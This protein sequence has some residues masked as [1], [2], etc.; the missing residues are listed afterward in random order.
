MS[1][2]VFVICLVTN[3]SYS[4]HITSVVVVLSVEVLSPFVIYIYT[5]YIHIYVKDGHGAGGNRQQFF[6]AAN[7]NKT[8][9]CNNNT[10]V[11]HNVP[12]I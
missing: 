7:Q 2:L 1:L 8:R 3:T 6:T 12:H 9:P 11:T 4:P 10:S 5:V